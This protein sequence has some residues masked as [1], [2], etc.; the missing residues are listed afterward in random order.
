MNSS[1]NAIDNYSISKFSKFDKS[2]PCKIYSSYI[3]EEPQKCNCTREN[4]SNSNEIEVQ[5][6]KEE[7]EKEKKLKK[8]KRK[9]KVKEFEEDKTEKEK[10]YKKYKKE[11]KSKKEKK[12]KNEK[13]EKEK[14][15]EK[16]DKFIGKGGFSRVYKSKIMIEIAKKIINNKKLF[17]KE[18]YYLKLLNNTKIKKN[19][20]KF[21]K[22]DDKKNILYLELCEGNLKLLRK[23]I[24]KKY[25]NKFPLFIIQDIMNQINKVMKY[26]IFNLKL[27]YNDMKPEN[28]LFKTKDEEKDLY[29][30]KL[31]DFNL[32]EK[33]IKKN[34][35]S[36]GIC[37]TYKYMDDDKKYEYEKNIYLYDQTSNEIYSLGNIM[38]YLFYGKVFD[39]KD[40][41]IKKIEDED[42]KYILINTLTND[43]EKIPINEYFNAK[44]FSKDKKDLKD[45]IKEKE[46][47][48]SMK[49]AEEIARKID[50]IDKIKKPKILDID[51]NVINE[52][53]SSNVKHFA[54][55]NENNVFNLVCYNSKDNQIEIYKENNIKY[56]KCKNKII[57]IEKNINNVNDILIHDNY[58]IILSS[59][60]CYL[61]I[62]KNF[63]QN[64]IDIKNVFSK[65]ITLDNKKIIIYLNENKEI[66]SFEFEIN[67]ETNEFKIIK[68]NSMIKIENCE[69]KIKDFNCFKTSKND[70]LIY[71]YTNNLIQIYN[72]TNKKLIFSKEKQEKNI[73][74]ISLLL[75]EID[76]KIN[77]I[78]LTT[79]KQERKQLIN[80]LIFKYENFN[81]KLLK[82]KIE[83]EKFITH[84]ESRK[85]DK[86]NLF[87]ND[88]LIIKT[89]GNITL[90]D[91]KNEIFYSHSKFGV[92]YFENIKLCNH[93]YYGN[94]ILS[95]RNLNKEKKI[96]NLF[97]LRDFSCDYFKLKSI[98]IKKFANELFHFKLN[99]YICTVNYYN[100]MEMILVERLMILNDED[101]EELFKLI[102]E[103]KN[104][105][106]NNIDLK[107]N[108]LYFQ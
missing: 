101:N 1:I 70:I 31:C 40:K 28:I 5:T 66:G 22:S 17:K 62:K 71:Y 2:K 23:K 55:F 33:N 89:A 57:K 35:I 41:E 103:K 18:K 30:I 10:K 16:D 13:D 37:G 64:F 75:T 61:N 77:V 44:F 7:D 43:A 49:D 58:I 108:N 79:N 51:S 27:V 56:E 74:I 99:E 25:N 68:E 84:K 50:K 67:D 54:S 94:C 14:D 86:L 83:K 19:I 3:S 60:I 100:N 90:Y 82:L 80:I 21:Y 52:Q 53:F 97:H 59:P 20:V 102:K 11:K 39:K 93:F 76:N 12:F 96:L 107:E 4:T 65:F 88:K 47:E 6:I 95:L 81:K 78:Y 63:S 38:Y 91:L 8:R 105:I 26:L 34:G 36:K 104:Q 42:F 73:K 9:T 69:E 92:N 15:I 98:V 106:H 24:I 87:S 72:L 46:Y 29:K 32:V 48:F 45:G 85:M